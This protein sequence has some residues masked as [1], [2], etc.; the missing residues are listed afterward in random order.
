MNEIKGL[1]TCPKQ[2]EILSQQLDAIAYF[3]FYL[4]NTYTHANKHT[5]NINDLDTNCLAQKWN[6]LP[7]H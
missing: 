3:P 7:L 4:P 5:L 2:V 1:P 6:A